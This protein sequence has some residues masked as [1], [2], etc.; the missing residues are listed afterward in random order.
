M[1]IQRQGGMSV[2]AGNGKVFINGE[3]IYVPKDMNLGNQTIINGKVYIGGYEFF[4][5]EKRFR[6]SLAAWWH[7]FF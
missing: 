7:L 5:K 4:P 2:Q 6:R 1:N 3:Q